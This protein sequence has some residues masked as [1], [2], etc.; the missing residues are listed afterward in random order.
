MFESGLRS[1]RVASPQEMKSAY[2][3]VVGSTL[4]GN[5]LSGDFRGSGAAGTV[6]SRQH[7]R[8]TVYAN[9]HI[10]EIGDT[11]VLTEAQVPRLRFP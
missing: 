4:T 1:E 6:A 8:D 3:I 5:R 7:R 2:F 10:G 9:A 11:D